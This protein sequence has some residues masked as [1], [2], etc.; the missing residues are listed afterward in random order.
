MP[1]GQAYM[2]SFSLSLPLFLSLSL[3]LCLPVC[4]SLSLSLT[5][6]HAPHTHAQP[7]SW[8]ASARSSRH[9]GPPRSSQQESDQ[10]LGAPSRT[11]GSITPSRRTRTATQHAIAFSKPGGGRHTVGSAAAH[12]APAT[13]QP[14]SCATA[15]SLRWHIGTAAAH[16]PPGAR[17]APGEVAVLV[18]EY[19]RCVSHWRV[20][21][22]PHALFLIPLFPAGPVH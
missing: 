6:S 5:L 1:G 18:I 10:S 8:K 3:S 17:I 13:Q 14:H 20:C 21:T 15:K 4:L 12:A 2:G 16:A 7:H 11:A 9:S 22:G 19:A